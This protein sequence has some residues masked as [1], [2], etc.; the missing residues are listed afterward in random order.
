MALSNT[1]FD[2]LLRQSGS[3]SQQFGGQ[4]SQDIGTAG[5][6]FRTLLGGNR[7]AQLQ[8]IAPSAN[9][10]R[11]MADA[12]RNEVGR[13]GGGRTGGATAE[14]ATTEDELRKQVDTLLGGLQQNAAS[15]LAGTGTSEMQA[16]LDS[17]K[18]GLGAAQQDVASRR[19][20]TAS[21]LGSLI[22]GAGDI[23][24]GAASAGKL[25]GI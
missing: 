12:R 3:T 16:A 24:G 8:A 22:G 18:T 25:F 13:M 21:M 17:L 11:A 19:A 10:A 20:A 6:F 2:Q 4:G 23:L 14:Q 15:S 9:A 7:Q 5:N 1:M